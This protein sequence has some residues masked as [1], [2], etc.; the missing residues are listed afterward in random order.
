MNDFNE[1]LNDFGCQDILFCWQ[2]TCTPGDAACL[3]SCIDNDPGTSADLFNTWAS[4]VVCS[5]QSTCAVSS[6]C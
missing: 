1:C 6:G 2:C 5:C 4:C 3:Q